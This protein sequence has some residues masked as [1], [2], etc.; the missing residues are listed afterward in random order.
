MVLNNYPADY[1]SLNGDLIYTVYDSTKVSD[2]VTYVGYQYVCDV[3]VGGTQIARLKAAPNPVNGRGIFNIGRA[4]R[5]YLAF[6]FNPTASAFKVQEFGDTEFRLS[7]QCKFGE[8]YGGT[9]YTNIITDSSRKFYN[10]YN[11][12]L[13]SA[14]TILPSYLDKLGT[15]APATRYV[16][17]GKRCFMPYVSTTTG[18]VAVIATAYNAAGSST[19]SYTGTL[20]V[21]AYNISIVDIGGLGINALAGS[22]LITASTA[23]YTVSINGYVTTVYVYCEPKFTPYSIHFLNKLGGF[24]SFDFRK[25]SRKTLEFEKKTYQQQSYRIDS[26]GV[27]SIRTSGNVMY[28]ADTVYAVNYSEKMK[29][30][31]DITTDA[32]YQWLSELVLSPVVYFDDSSYLV[33]VT[34]TDTSYEFKKYINDKI[35]SLMINIDFGKKLNTQFR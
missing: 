1:S 35:T 29:L 3:Y 17:Y 22:S 12:R 6:Q 26:S 5:N 18:T 33:P 34:I 21:T 32:Q 30:Y 9:T 28:D 7:V 19:G 13:T 20:S 4:V 16:G 2:P 25:L 8:D 11:G 27:S 10:H 15:N 24:E 31:A 14:D 23:Y